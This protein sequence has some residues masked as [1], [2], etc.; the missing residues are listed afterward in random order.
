MITE[1]V[2]TIIDGHE[3]S[4]PAHLM[5]VEPPKSTRVL[6]PLSVATAN[7]LSGNIIFHEIRDADGTI[8]SN[9]WGGPNAEL[10]NLIASA[11]NAYDDLVEALLVALPYVEDC[12]N[13]SD[14]KP[15]IVKKHVAA[16]R[17]ALRKAGVA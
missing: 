12:E 13:S 9:T 10:A 6:L 8:V 5:P 3:L 4:V 16:I 7:D 1:H 11:A 14:F 2:N 15:G 17:L